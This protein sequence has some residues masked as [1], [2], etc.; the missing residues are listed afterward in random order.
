M[1]VLVVSAVHPLGEGVGQA[2]EM[3]V[4]EILH[5]LAGEQGCEV[6]YGLVSARPPAP[7]ETSEIGYAALRNLGIRFLPPVTLD[8]FPPFH[9]L[10]YWMGVLAGDR[11]AL[12]R[13]WGQSDKL[14]TA[15]Q[16]IV[17]WEPDVVLPVWSYEATYCA[18]GLSYPVCQF[19]GNPDHN[20][21]DAFNRVAWRWERVA[22]A[23]W[24]AACPK[25]TAGRVLEFVHRRVLSEFPLIWENARNDVDYYHAYG[26]TNVH[27][28]RNMW[29]PPED[30]DCFARRDMLGAG[31]A[32]KNLWQP[33]APR[34]D[35]EYFRA[36][37]YW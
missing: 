16:T 4:W 35:R 1:R 25:P 31:Y 28:L 2:A 37:G 20:L 3:A 33:W 30:D 13:G 15:M 10:R 23:R 7:T 19:H 9:G 26:M 11:R 6:A 36:L 14:R 12:L 21:I 8:P 27:Y 22:S 18:V 32:A 5:R 29:P 17:P 34:G 24:L